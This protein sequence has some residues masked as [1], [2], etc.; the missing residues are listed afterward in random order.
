M[1]GH[2]TS[3]V[4]S[5]ITGQVTGRSVIGHVTMNYCNYCTVSPQY[6]VHVHWFKIRVDTNTHGSYQ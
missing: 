2:V 4:T 6:S 1:P 5:Y 3:H